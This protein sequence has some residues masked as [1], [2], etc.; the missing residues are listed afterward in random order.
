MKKNKVLLVTGIIVFIIMGAWLFSNNITTTEVNAKTKESDSVVLDKKVNS[1]CEG[2]IVYGRITYKLIKKNGLCWL[3]KNLEANF[4]CDSPTNP[5]CYGALY[6]WG[7]LRDGHQYRISDTTGEL[8]PNNNPGHN[9]YIVAGKVP[10]DWRS[11]RNDNLWNNFHSYNIVNNPCPD[12]FRVP[13]AKEL[14]N[15]MNSWSPQ[16]IKGAFAS[17][18][19]WPASGQRVFGSVLDAG[20]N[21]YVWSSDTL[22]EYGVGIAWDK[23]S[24]RVNPNFREHGMPVRCV[25]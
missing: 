20:T 23:D 8:S 3:N 9:N 6:Q 13:N 16:N 7:R 21:G 15:E 24:V 17:E 10:Y 12:G 11:P 22:H 14:Y 4:A 5:D 19:K 1:N 2:R 25:R 18:L